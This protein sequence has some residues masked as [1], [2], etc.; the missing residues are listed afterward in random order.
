M[1]ETALPAATIDCPYCSEPINPKSKKCK[2]CGEILDPQMREI[3]LLKSQRNS[4][5][6]FMNAG[7]GAAAAA[8]SGFGGPVKRFPHWI[9]ILLVILSSG[10]WLPVYILM[11]LFRNKRYYY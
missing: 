9:H 4:P 1:D 8:A 2:H 5:Q 10:L 11:Y 6:V 7:G 3:E